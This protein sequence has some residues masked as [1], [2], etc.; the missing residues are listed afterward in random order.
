MYTGNGMKGDRT[1]LPGTELY[2]LSK[3]RQKSVPDMNILCI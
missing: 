1:A 3:Y 2:A